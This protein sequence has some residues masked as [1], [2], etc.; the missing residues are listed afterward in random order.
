MIKIAFTAPNHMDLEKTPAW[1]S[2]LKVKEKYPQHVIS[3][4]ANINL[5]RNKAVSEKD[6]F[7]K[8]QTDFNFDKILFIDSDIEF[9]E[10]N[11]QSLGLINA[12]IVAGVYR[13]TPDRLSAGVWSGMMGNCSYVTPGTT[14]IKQVGWASTGFMMGVK[15]VFMTM[16]YP[17]FR[18]FLIE[19]V[20]EA[21]ETSEDIGFCIQAEK[22]QIKVIANFDVVLKHHKEG[23]L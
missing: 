20:E 1:Q 21:S 4:G 17:W 13:V 18:C 11:I 19:T 9:T 5:V 23:L 10:D 14:G 3:R 2:Y 15:E 22:Y 12:P 6:C 16:P 8:F 7:K